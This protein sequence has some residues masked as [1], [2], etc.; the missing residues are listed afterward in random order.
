MLVFQTTNSVA[1][2]STHI[3]SRTLT[4]DLKNKNKKNVLPLM[5]C[6]IC[7]KLDQ[8]KL[9]DFYFF[10]YYN[11]AFDVKQPIQLQLQL[12]VL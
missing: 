3:L 7:A 2:T 9:N 11:I 10:R 12:D 6:N 4:H 8:N 5:L 1:S